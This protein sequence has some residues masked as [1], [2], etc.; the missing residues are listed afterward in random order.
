MEE[1]SVLKSGDIA[2]ALSI[3]RLSFLY[4]D[5]AKQ[6]T[7]HFLTQRIVLYLIGGYK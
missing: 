3:D 2:Q 4:K 6:I 1:I 5:V 7:S